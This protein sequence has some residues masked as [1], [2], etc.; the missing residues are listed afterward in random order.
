MPTMPPQQT[1]M[2]ALAHALQRVEAVL[3]GARGDDLAVELGRGV[4]VVVVVVEPG[5]LQLLRLV[6]AR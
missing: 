6:C 5:V 1:F 4:E 2:P 3:V